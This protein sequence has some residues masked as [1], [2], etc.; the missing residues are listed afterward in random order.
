MS[1]NL[2]RRPVA[3]R[4]WSKVSGGDVTTCWQWTGAANRRTGYGSFSPEK[5]EYAMPHR[6]AY[7]ALRAE[8]PAGLQIDHLCRNRLCVN[9]WHL[10]PVTPRVNARRSL[11]PAGINSRREACAKGHPLTDGNVYKVAGTPN[12]RCRICTRR[13]NRGYEVAKRND[14]GAGAR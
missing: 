1:P 14:S 3:E 4:F 2:R 13:R 11:S 12:R 9:P 7:E 5:G 6:F 8:I 10:E